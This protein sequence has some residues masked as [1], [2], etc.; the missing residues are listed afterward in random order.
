[1]PHGLWLRLRTFAARRA[2]LVGALFILTGLIGLIGVVAPSAASNGL[3]DRG[4]APARSAADD[5]WRVWGGPRR[6]FVTTATGLFPRS[7]PSWLTMPPKKLWER[8]LGD[9][10]SAIAAEAGVLLRD[11]R[12]IMALDLSVVR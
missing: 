1:M 3:Q 8:A 6:D 4:G 7:G 5:S 10:H 2:V 9:G 11:R 12:T